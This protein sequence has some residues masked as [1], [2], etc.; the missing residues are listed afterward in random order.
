MNHPDEWPVDHLQL[1]NVTYTEEQLLE[2]LHQPVEGNC[3]VSLAHQLIATK[4]NIDNGAPHDCIDPD[5]ATADLDIGDLIIPPIGDGSLPCNISGLIQSLDDYNN[6][7]LC[8]EHC[9]NETD[10]VHSDNPCIQRP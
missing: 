5:V 2:I 6:G 10:P 4:L 9:R 1:G 3:L 8:A 7:R